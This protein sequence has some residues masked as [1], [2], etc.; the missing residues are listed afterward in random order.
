MESCRT[1]QWLLVSNAQQT[2]RVVSDYSARC[3][4]RKGSGQTA[5]P[6]P[7]GTIDPICGGSR[8]LISS[9]TFCAISGEEETMMSAPGTL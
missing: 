4:P 5:A 6:D 9:I 3:S 8:C 7:S 1:H 2:K